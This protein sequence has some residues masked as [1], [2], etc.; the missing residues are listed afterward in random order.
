MDL[1]RIYLAVHNQLQLFVLNFPQLAIVP[2]TGLQTKSVTKT[3]ENV[4]VWLDSLETNVKLV[5]NGVLS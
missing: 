2:M 5:S 3:L 4:C 1:S